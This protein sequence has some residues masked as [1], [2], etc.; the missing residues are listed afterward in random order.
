MF[1]QTTITITKTAR[2]LKCQCGY[3][4]YYSGQRD[5]ICSCPKCHS[6]VRINRAIERIAQIGQTLAGTDQS[7]A[8]SPQQPINTGG[9]LTNE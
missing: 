2:R 4:W 1:N 8:I 9:T 6:S 5:N 3:E 7:A